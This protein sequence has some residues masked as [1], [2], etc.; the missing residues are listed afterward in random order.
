MGDMLRNYRGCGGF[1]L[2]EPEWPENESKIFSFEDDFPTADKVRNR[3]QKLSATDITILGEIKRLIDSAND[4]TSITYEGC[5]SSAAKKFLCEKG[6][7]ISA[8]RQ[9]NTDYIVI[10]WR[11]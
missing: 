6:Y 7:K 10:S 9:Y 11:E 3:K 4:C 2:Y 8:V 1:P 5:L